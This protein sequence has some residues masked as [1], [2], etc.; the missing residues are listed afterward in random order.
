LYAV[1]FAYA[2]DEFVKDV[3]VMDIEVYITL[4]DTCIATDDEFTDV[5]IHLVRYL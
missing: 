1:Y 4:K 3:L 2:L 5:D